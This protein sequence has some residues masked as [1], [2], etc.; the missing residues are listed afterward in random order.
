MNFQYRFKLPVPVEQAWPVLLDVRRVAPCM[1]GAGIES[2]EGDDYVGR[3]KVKLGPIEMAYRG[4]LHFVERDDA[5]HRLKVEGVGKEVR[6]GGGAKALVTMQASSV[7]GGCEVAI[8]SEYELNGRAA[9]FGTGMIDEIGGKLM[10]EFARR[11][12]RLILNSNAQEGGP[13]AVTA[14]APSTP[15]PA[16]V[17]SAGGQDWT[18]DDNEALD[19]VGLAWGPVLSRSLP[20]IHLLISA[21]TLIY[22]VAHG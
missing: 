19:L 5:N 21:A 6:G 2:G 22:L 3:M 12:E 13:A 18:A 4:D 16:A 9:Q 1:P 17:A 10:Q 8:D 11:L 15:Q 20:V 7:P 14:S